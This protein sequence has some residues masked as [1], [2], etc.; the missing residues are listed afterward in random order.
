MANNAHRYRI[1]VTPVESDGLQCLGRCTIEFEHSCHDDWMRIL[2]AQQQRG[3]SGDE[4]A[5]LIVGTKLLSGLMLEHRKDAN[6]VFAP[7]RP[8]MGEFIKG[9]K[10]PNTVA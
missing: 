2:E 7:L 5:A 9:L 3:F 1:T 6:D 4:R 10:Q 8:H